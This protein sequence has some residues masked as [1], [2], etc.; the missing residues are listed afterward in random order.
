MTSVTGAMISM[1]QAP[2]VPAA[3]GFEAGQREIAILFSF[4][5]TQTAFFDCLF[6]S[7]ALQ[8]VC[9]EFILFKCLS[10]ATET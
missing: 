9:F 8:F 7:E 4:W 10:A 1:C 6:V 3:L 2:A 5:P